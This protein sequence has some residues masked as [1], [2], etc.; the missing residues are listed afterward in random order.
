MK[1]KPRL[2]PGLKIY[3]ERQKKRRAGKSRRR[4]RASPNQIIALRLQDFARLFRSRYG[5][6][7]LP[8]DDS[9]RHDIMPVLHH[10]AALDRPKRRIEVWF[11]L[12]AP[13]MA[14]G[15][16]D[17]MAAEALATAKP[18]KAD[19]LAWHYHITKEE[20]RMIGLTTIGAVDHQKAARTRRRKERD[21]QRKAAARRAAGAKP[22]ADYLAASAE[23]AK[24]WEAEGISRRTWYR[25]RAETDTG[26]ATA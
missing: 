2:S 15:E 9:G 22:R 11:R 21:R 4:G 13:W 14:F 6:P 26:P 8:D 1:P 25:R 3:S 17:A 18:W 19:T 24:P 16:Q 7:I 12:W 5:A 23:R 10:L 20:R